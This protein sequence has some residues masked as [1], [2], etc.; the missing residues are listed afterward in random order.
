ML[1]K[2][3]EK[4]IALFLYFNSKHNAMWDQVMYWV[5]DRLFWIP[6]YMAIVIFVILKYKRNAWVILLSIAVLIL[7][8]DQISSGLLKPWV[9]RLR[10]C[11]EPQLQ[12][13]VHLVRGCG[14][15]YG[16]VSS[17]A[18]NTFALVTF[19]GLV[20]RKR[21]KVIYIGLLFAWACLVSYS[22]I[23]VGV[24][25]PLDVFGGGCLGILLAYSLFK[26]I[27]YFWNVD[28]LYKK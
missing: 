25:Y 8:A 28:K 26:L 11:H 16:F 4:D 2:I 12:G 6:L 7:L 10:P 22:R 23:Y 1:E 20:L 3:I 9:E 27:S 19:L 18:A 17:H 14:G 13:L 5:T 24:H 15:K 21:I